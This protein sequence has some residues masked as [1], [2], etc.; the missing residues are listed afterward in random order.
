MKAV[1]H[2]V[3]QG[4]SDRRA[5][6]SRLRKSSRLLAWLLVGGLCTRCA[7]SSSVPRFSSP[8]PGT[9]PRLAWWEIPDCLPCGTQSE[10]NRP[11]DP[12]LGPE[13][14]TAPSQQTSPAKDSPETT[15]SVE[16]STT[17]PPAGPTRPQPSPGAWRADPEVETDS[18][19]DAVTD[20][21]TDAV[22]KPDA[23]TDA[24]AKPDAVADGTRPASVLVPP[25]AGGTALPVPTDL[26]STPPAQDLPMLPAAPGIPDAE[27]TTAL[28]LAA[29]QP[30]RPPAASPAAPDA[31]VSRVSA[32][33]GPTKVASSDGAGIF[34]PSPPAQTREALSPPPATGRTGAPTSGLVLQEGSVVLEY[35]SIYQ[36][37]QKLMGGRC[38]AFISVQ[39]MELD[40]TRTDGGFLLDV[41]NSSLLV[42]AYEP[43][44]YQADGFEVQLLIQSARLCLARASLQNGIPLSRNERSL[45]ILEEGFAH[46]LKTRAELASVGGQPLST[47]RFIAYAAQ[48][49]LRHHVDLD[50]LWDRLP[51]EPTFSDPN[52]PLH[53][54]RQEAALLAG[55]FVYDLIERQGL[56]LEGF[57][58]LFEAVAANPFKQH[59][60]S[61]SR[62][63]RAMLVPALSAFLAVA[64]EGRISSLEAAWNDFSVY[65]LTQQFIRPT[66][67]VWREGPRVRVAFSAPM[68]PDR[69]DITVDGVQLGPERLTSGLGRWLDERT[70]ELDLG[71]YQQQLGLKSVNR[72]EINFGR[73]WQWFRGIEGIPAEGA[74]LQLSNKSE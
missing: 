31:A 38:P 10:A 22:A 49:E 44:Y 51:D 61:P 40:G 59:G 52:L 73:I 66:T 23:V 5:Q 8:S 36:L 71:M 2:T 60:S 19:P 62:I 42:S 21:A 20:A 37:L 32:E 3:G 15:S 7:T 50:G 56:G 45:R 17:R 72:V 30:V 70:L 55:G 39:R 4:V 54:G 64:S 26:V 28:D 12:G 34:E 69:I 16:A 14:W 57:I 68:Q 41:P 11:R 67:E 47:R 29:F 24:V 63:P 18:E 13:E 27:A 53:P 33:S 35:P 48:I 65:V 9:Q 43:E 58:R 6:L 74:M 46:Y 1:V 25:E